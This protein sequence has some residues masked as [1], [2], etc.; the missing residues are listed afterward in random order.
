MQSTV[1]LTRRSTVVRRCEG[2]IC[3]PFAPCHPVSHIAKASP[4]TEEPKTANKSE[5]ELATEKF[6]LEAGLLTALTSKDEG[7]E[8]KLSNTEQ[9]KRLLAQYGSAYLI[10]SISFAIVSFAACYLAVD[11]GVDMAGVLA[12]FG[13]EASDTSEKVGTFALA[14]AAHKA[15]SPV[16]FPP[17]VALTPVVAKYL[18]K[19]K[20]EPSSG[21]NS[22]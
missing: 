1:Q 16:R 2:R 15:L 13:L 20:E 14:Y 11:S 12:R 22:K 8:G 10:T 9:A 5:A 19:K 6:G 4:A 21:S 17:T 7:G 3:R 18:G